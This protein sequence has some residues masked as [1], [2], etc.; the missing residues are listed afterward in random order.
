MRLFVAGDTAV[1]AKRSGKKKSYRWNVKRPP[2]RQVE[3]IRIKS[4]TGPRADYSLKIRDILVNWTAVN[5]GPHSG[6]S[7]YLKSLEHTGLCFMRTLYAP[8]CERHRNALS[9]IPIGAPLFSIAKTTS[10]LI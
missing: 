9:P 6:L 4:S 7:P 5:P 3:F 10:G 8:D 1:L 2:L